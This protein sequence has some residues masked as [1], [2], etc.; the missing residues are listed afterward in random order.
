MNNVNYLL[1][2]KEIGLPYGIYGQSFDRFAWP[3]ELLF[4]LR[5]YA[6]YQRLI[7]EQNR[8]QLDARAIARR[9]SVSL[10]M[11]ERTDAKP[12]AW[13]LHRGA[14]D[15]RREQLEAGTPSVLP[16]M[17]STMPR[18]RLGLAQWL[19]SREGHCGEGEGK[20]GQGDEGLLHGWVSKS[21]RAKSS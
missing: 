16:P 10:V 6:P 14:Y 2:A 8:L 5:E 21:V 15:Q 13:I 9:G 18:N 12:M 3:S 1:Y 11:E 20:S 19:V 4:L 7:E 17:T